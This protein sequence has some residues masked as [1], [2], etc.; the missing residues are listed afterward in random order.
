M[1]LIRLIQTKVIWQGTYELYY[2]NTSTILK[3][4]IRLTAKDKGKPILLPF[5]FTTAFKRR[6]PKVTS[7]LRSWTL[8]AVLSM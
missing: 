2:Q 3:I 8:S 7:N 4:H 6:R 5:T 1:G